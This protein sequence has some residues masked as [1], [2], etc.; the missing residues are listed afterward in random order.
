[1]ENR[2]WEREVSYRVGV[3]EFD[4]G[5]PNDELNRFLGFADVRTELASV[6]KPSLKPS[7]SRLGNVNIE[8]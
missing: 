6:S 4:S 7:D 1:M 3:L 2:E 8:L 5:A